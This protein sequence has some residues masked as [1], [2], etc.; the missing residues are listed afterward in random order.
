[1]HFAADNKYGYISFFRFFHSSLSSCS[2]TLVVVVV[3][4]IAGDGDEC[5]RR[6][7]VVVRDES[8]GTAGRRLGNTT[9]SEIIDVAT[10]PV[11][12]GTFVEVIGGDEDGRMRRL[13]VVVG[14]ESAGTVM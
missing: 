4:L 8:V 2:L 10:A 1:M 7:V 12:I 14:D 11:S 3:V 5:M 9:S 13:V 6:V